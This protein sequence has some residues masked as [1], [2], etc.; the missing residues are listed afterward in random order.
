MLDQGEGDPFKSSTGNYL[1]G[2][3]IFFLNLGRQKLD[4]PVSLIIGYLN[5]VILRYTEDLIINLNLN[6]TVNFHKHYLVNEIK[7][8]NKW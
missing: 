3:I 8:D 5:K 1:L 7:L 2:M 4:P 6:Q